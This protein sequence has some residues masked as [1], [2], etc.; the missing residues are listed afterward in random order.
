MIKPAAIRNHLVLIGICCAVGCGVLLVSTDTLD[1]FSGEPKVVKSA[2]PTYA[3]VTKVQMEP[4]HSVCRPR[5]TRVGSANPSQSLVPPT[6]S[7]DMSVSLLSGAQVHEVGGGSDAGGLGTL[8]QQ[9]VQQFGGVSTM[10]ITTFYAKAST[11]HIATPGAAA[12]PQIAE[13]TSGPR[14]LGGL[15]PPVIGDDDDPEN[16]DLPQPPVPVGDA[17]GVLALMATA[18]ACYK[19]C[20]T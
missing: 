14:K 16:P 12:A 8:H 3:P 20:K 11:R 1:I 2:V 13:M 7:F 10:P 4:M 18:F 15:N 5:T 6:A 17:L 19:R 9:Q